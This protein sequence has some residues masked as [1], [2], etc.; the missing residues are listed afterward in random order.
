MPSTTSLPL[1]AA[2]TSASPYSRWMVYTLISLALVCAWDFAG[3][4]VAM[5]QWWGDAQGFALRRNHFLVLYMHESMRMVGWAV[6]VALSIGVWFPF[7]VLRRLS[8]TRRIQWVVSILISLAVVGISKRIS[9]T[10]CP[11]DL[12]LFGGV[13][14]YVSH[15]RWGVQDGGG[16]H[17]FPAGHASAGFAFIGGYFALYR[18]APRYARAWLAFFIVLGLALGIGQQMRG[19]HF[20]SHTL[21]TGWLCWTTALVIDWATQRRLAKRGAAAD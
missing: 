3:Q 20:M 13:A 5:A 10:S 8:T 21:W 1:A 15:W 12:H 14:E 17:C 6:V 16:G 4:D 7:G 19:A 9:A 11:W 18:D 2:P